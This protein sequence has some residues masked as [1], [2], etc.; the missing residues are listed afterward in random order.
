MGQITQDQVYPYFK[1]SALNSSHFVWF[2]DQYEFYQSQNQ[3]IFAYRQMGPITLLA[4]E[5]LMP[6]ELATY[7]TETQQQ[8]QL[9]WQEFTKV[10]KPK[11]SAFVAVYS[12]FQA[13]LKNGGFESIK[14]GVEPWADLENYIPRGNAGKGVRSARNQAIRVGMRVEE[15]SAEL[16]QG[17]PEIQNKIRSIHEQWKNSR[18]LQLNHFLNA[19]DPFKYP[20]SR[21]Y[22]LL[23]DPSDQIKGYLIATEIPGIRS[24]FLEDLLLERSTPKGCAELL[25]LEAMRSLKESGV[26][27]ASLG[28]ISGSTSDASA[29]GATAGLPKSIR[30]LV[31]TL[32]KIA[33]RLY[34]FNGLEVFRKRFNPGFWKDIHLAVKNEPN[35]GYSDTQAW[36]LSL[37]MLLIAFK[38]RLKFSLRWLTSSAL[39]PLRKHPVS[40]S[41][42]VLS[43]ALFAT[44]NHFDTLPE[45]LISQ[46]AFANDAPLREWILR[47]VVSDFLYFDRIH[48]LFCVIPLVAILFW[49]EKSHRLQFTIPFVLAI[50]VFDDILNFALVIKPFSYFQPEFYQRLV[51]VKDVGGSL[52]LATLLGLQLCQIKRNREI[53]FTCLSMI[54]V[55]GFVYNSEHLKTLILNL[56]HFLFISLGYIS[57]K[58]KF[59]YERRQSR[60]VA[61]NRPPEGACVNGSEFNRSF[62]RGQNSPGGKNRSHAGNKAKSAQ[63]EK[64]PAHFPPIDRP[65]K[66]KGP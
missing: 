50:C 6:E 40:I 58:L 37:W 41:V 28:V 63:D 5:P 61:K 4:L 35:S 46:F 59:E 24:Y 45:K 60:A 14:I 65:P 51:D 1:K 15:I 57:G 36:I 7:S 27:T 19:V 13:L 23:K 18:I 52:W 11:I 66:R 62:G 48:F 10:I 47:S 54:A 38:P 55:F 12:P 42:A 32:P 9:A 2:L 56:N 3:W 49:T 21:R 64:H 44:L 26:N 53:I 29:T 31:G 25:T 22:F 43:F 8:F 34:N 17:S 39:N 33:N 16:I 30:Y 20:Q